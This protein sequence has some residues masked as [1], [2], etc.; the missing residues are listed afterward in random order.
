MDK[1]PAGALDDASAPAI[2]AAHRAAMACP[3][4][5]FRAKWIPVRVKKMR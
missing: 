3:S 1:M 2:Q 5:H 4:E